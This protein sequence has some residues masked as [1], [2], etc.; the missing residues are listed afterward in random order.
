MICSPTSDLALVSSIVS[1]PRIHRRM[2]NDESPKVSGY[3]ALMEE[4]QRIRG[5]MIVLVSDPEPIG[6]F[7]LAN[8]PEAR[9]PD[10]AEAYH[11]FL[12][13]VWGRTEAIL[14][15]CLSWVWR[16]TGIQRLTA[17]VPGYNRLSLRLALAV[18]FREVSR[19]VNVVIKGGRMFNVINLQI[20][21]P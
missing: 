11:C 15:E 9:F 8:V 6:I 10:A 3:L 17:R 16:E 5:D 7:V 19:A 14:R 21:K 1:E 13:S 12:P 2:C 20:D 4:S 18:G